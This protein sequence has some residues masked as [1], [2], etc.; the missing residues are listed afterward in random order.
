MRSEV[1]ICRQYIRVFNVVYKECDK[2]EVVDER[3]NNEQLK[4]ECI[5]F[6]V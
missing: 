1:Q 4:L 2:Q 6:I 3:T 5:S